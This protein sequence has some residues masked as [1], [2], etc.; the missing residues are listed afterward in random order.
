MKLLL[1]WQHKNTVEAVAV[2]LANAG[3]IDSYI[4]ETMKLQRHPLIEKT[5]IA[6]KSESF[7]FPPLVA[8]KHISVQLKKKFK[9]LLLSMNKNKHGKYLLDQLNID[10]FIDGNKQ[11]YDDILKMHSFIEANN[12]VASRY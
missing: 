1:T 5:R 11:L 6:H 9:R 8:T 2:G 10:G 3:I 4:W 12:H 7:G